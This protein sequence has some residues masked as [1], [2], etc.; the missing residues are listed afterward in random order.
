MKPVV[1]LVL[2]LLL[3][4]GTPVQ[5]AAGL[6]ELKGA[7]LVPTEWAD[8]DSFL[9]Q[10][11]DSSTGG[12]RRE[13]FRLY[14]VD[15]METVSTYESD[16]RRLLEQARHFGV[17]DPAVLIVQGRAARD[18]TVRRLQRPF[19]VHTAFSKALGRS[20]KSRYYAF[21]T[22]AEGRDLAA[23]LVTAG[24]ARVKGISRET[25]G[26]ISRAEYEAH[27]A[28]LELAAAMERTGIWKLSNPTRLAEFRAAKRREDQ[29]LSAIRDT[30]ETPTTL[31]I[32][33]ASL[34]EIEKLPG[35]GP[36]LARRILE[37]RPY[38]SPDDLL[39]VKGI[40][41]PTLEKLRP[42]LHGGQPL[43]GPVPQSQPAGQ[44]D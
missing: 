25:A 39:K 7:T 9:V 17:E 37:G 36:S 5:A 20:G 23:E 3:A 8:G 12:T 22:T 15:C 27:L 29:M 40:G 16:R 44:P 31:D 32:N 33:T 4:V 42:H 11:P 10:F 13:V 41:K 19:V 18:F 14:G 2:F 1:R 43:P 34:E 26:G 35:V 6:Q 38:D 28:D 24:L 21:I 30:P